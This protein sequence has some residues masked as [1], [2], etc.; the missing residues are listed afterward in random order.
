MVILGH[1]APR[2]PQRALIS[3]CPETGKL[4]STSYR[5]MLIRCHHVGLFCCAVR[6][7]E[8][9]FMSN[10]TPGPE[11]PLSSRP[12]TCA[13]PYSGGRCSSCCSARVSTI[14]ELHRKGAKLHS[15]LHTCTLTHACNTYSNV[16]AQVHSHTHATHS[17]IHICTLSPIHILAHMKHTCTHTDALICLHTTHMCPHTQVHI[18]ACP[19]MN[20]RKHTHRIPAA[21]YPASY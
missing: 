18:H 12:H 21:G 16:H 2:A 10:C 7:V 3:L 1:R 13:T 5:E 4:S 17:Y 9:V 15:Q 20:V 11:I 6:A 14:K 8:L 19:H